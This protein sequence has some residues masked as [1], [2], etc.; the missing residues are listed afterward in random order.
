MAHSD[1]DVVNLLAR[2][3]AE[4]NAGCNCPI[5]YLIERYERGQMSWASAQHLARVWIDE[6]GPRHRSEK[7]WSRRV[8]RAWLD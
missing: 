5:C 1:A 4:W 3:R 7:L 6:N 2:A 8:T